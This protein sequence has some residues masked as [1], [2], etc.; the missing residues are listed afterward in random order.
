MTY[1]KGIKPGRK[2]IAGI[3]SALVDILSHESDNTL[4]KIGGSKGGMTLVDSDFIENI[5]KMLQ[6][7][8]ILSPGGAACNAINGIGKLGGNSR[9]VAKYGND[10]TGL[11]FENGLR[12]SGVETFLIKSSLPTGRVVSVITEDAQRTMFTY[13]GASAELHPDEVTEKSFEN[14]A[15]VFIE[16]Y[17][18]FNRDLIKKA[19]EC[20]KKAGA[21]IVLD[22]ASYTVVESSKDILEDLISEY[23]D[24]LIANE[25]EARS[26]TGVNDEK[27]SL[28]IFSKKVDIA[29]IKIGKRGS[30]IN[31]ED[32][33][34]HIEPMGD[35]SAVDTTGA[36]DLWASGFLYGIV[37]GFDINKS[38]K[39]AS[40]CG[41]EVCQVDGAVIPEAGWDRIRKIII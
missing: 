13:L 10:Q 23:V 19:L 17:L 38:G 26:F 18:L 24:I 7:K 4:S 20:A 1:Y 12:S 33:T 21:V 3:G 35:G 31:Y 41:Y 32:K 30:L 25:D 29:V 37:N 5:L 34:Y 16:G 14:C 40:A 11:F 39:I 28:K 6:N 22:L 36:G 15:M 27:E 8:P 2:T 9:F